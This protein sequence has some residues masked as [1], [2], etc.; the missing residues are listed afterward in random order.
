MLF[1]IKN[2]L[3]PNYLV[4]LLPG[5]NPPSTQYDLRRHVNIVRPKVRLRCYDQSFIP[6]SVSLWNQLPA[7]FVTLVNIKTFRIKLNDH[8]A[9]Q[10][11]N[12][13]CKKSFILC[14]CTGFFGKVLNQIR[15]GLS[16]LN[17]HL[18]SYSIVDNPFC[19]KCLNEIEDPK[20]FFIDCVFYNDIR[21]KL[22]DA[23][24]A[25]LN[26][27]NVQIDL[28]DSN[29]LLSIVMY[30]INSDGNPFAQANYK[31]FIAVKSYMRESVRFI[32][33]NFS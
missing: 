14:F 16:P 20:H 31:L 15:Y 33:P 24:G 18:F 27:H 12:R 22:I 32:D 6:S 1:K 11:T 29:K 30:G 25:I 4:N 19:P 21:R 26:F 10:V 23:I 8:F 7:D 3:V 17:F 28:N 9:N 2:A 13:N 5:G